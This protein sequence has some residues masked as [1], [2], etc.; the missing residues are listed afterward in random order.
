ME[1]RIPPALSFKLQE[2][3]GLS[4]AE[5][6]AQVNA[7]AVFLEKMAEQKLKFAEVVRRIQMYKAAR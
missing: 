2:A 6:K 4:E 3:L 1:Q 5:W 7:R